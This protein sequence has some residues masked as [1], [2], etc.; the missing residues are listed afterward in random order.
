MNEKI[1]TSLFPNEMKA[2]EKG[3]CPFCLEPIK[4][5]EF[6]DAISRAEFKLSGICQS[7]QDLTFEDN[8]DIWR[9]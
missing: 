1:M 8:E 5:N 6:K 9:K 4:E 2:R 7:C 3:L